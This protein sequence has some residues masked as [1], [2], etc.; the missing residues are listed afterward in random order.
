VQEIS[1]DNWICL[2]IVW[3][4]CGLFAGLLYRNKGRSEL[5]GCLGGV[6]LGPVGLIL[7]LVSPTNKDALEQ[8]ERAKLEEKVRKGQLKKCP[9]CGEFILPEASVCKH[10]GRDIVA[11][12]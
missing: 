4:V 8:R 5:L 3:F 1:V 7:A 6:L 12:A 11:P 9:H 10:C 2:G